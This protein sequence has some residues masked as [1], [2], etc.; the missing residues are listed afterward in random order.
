MAAPSPR[1]LETDTS[2]QRVDENNNNTTNEPPRVVETTTTTT[3]L[4]Q[5]RNRLRTKTVHDSG[6]SRL[7][8]TNLERKYIRLQKKTYHKPP[9]LQLENHLKTEH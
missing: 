1:V 8:R 9:V 4:D 6:Q 3:A 2:A 7:V 5:F